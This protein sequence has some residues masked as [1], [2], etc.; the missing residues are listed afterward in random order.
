MGGV[1]FRQDSEEA[2]HRF[3]KAGLNPEIYMGAYGQK[4]FFLDLETGTTDS[5]AFLPQDGIGIRTKPC[6]MGRGTVLLARLHTRCSN[7][8]PPRPDETP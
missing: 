5:E 2:F 7:R 4:D 6:D 8:T 1:I 3:R